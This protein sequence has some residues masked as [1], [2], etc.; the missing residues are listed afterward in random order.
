[1]C[2]QIRFFVLDEADRLLD[3][4]DVIMKIFKRLPKG[5]SGLARLQVR[6]WRVNVCTPL[7]A[8]AAHALQ[9]AYTTLQ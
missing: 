5:G 6:G 8:L 9:E 3:S 7:L 4:E 2:A 1:M